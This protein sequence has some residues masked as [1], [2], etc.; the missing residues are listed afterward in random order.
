[1]RFIL[2]LRSLNKFIDTNH[3]KVE[4]LRIVIKL[5]S[6]DYYLCTVDLKDAYFLIRVHKEDRRYLRFQ[7]ENIIYEFNLT[8]WLEYD[9]YRVYES[10]EAGRKITKGTWIFFYNLLR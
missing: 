4:D 1:M 6:I 3:F 5:I 8:L 2:N 7:F 10:D 9:S